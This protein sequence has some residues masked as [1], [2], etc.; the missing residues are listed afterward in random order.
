[1]PTNKASKTESL[2]AEPLSLRLSIDRTSAQAI[3][4]GRTLASTQVVATG[5][6]I[7][8]PNSSLTSLP[9]EAKRI[10]DTLHAICAASADTV[11]TWGGRPHK[12][13]SPHYANAAKGTQLIGRPGAERAAQIVIAPVDQPEQHIFTK[14]AVVPN[15]KWE[16][17]EPRYFLECEGNPTTLIAGN[18]IL[19]VTARN[20]ETK[21]VEPYPSSAP[22]VMTTLNR[23]LFRF[24]EDVAMQITGSK[25]G[26]FEPETRR[27]IASGNFAIVHDQWCCYLPADVSRFLQVLSAIF[28]PRAATKVGGFTSLAKQMGLSFEDILDER[29]GRVSAVKLEKRHGKNAAWSAVFYNKR[30]RV[31][32]M[33]QGKTL[34][35]DERTLIASNV[36]FDM[37]AHTVGIMRIIERAVDYLR[38]HRDQ[39]AALPDTTRLQEFIEGDPK[40][41]ARWL[42]FAVFILSHRLERGRMRRGSFEDYLVPFFLDDV[43]QLPSIVCCTPEGLQ[44]LEE[45]PDQVAKAWCEDKSREARGWA[46][47]LAK[48]ANCSD[49]VVYECRDD[50]LLTHGINI[51]IPYAYYRDLHLQPAITLMQDDERE[52]YHEARK[53]GDDHARLRVLDKAGENLFSQMREFVGVPISTP[54]TLLRAKVLGD[55]LVNSLQSRQVSSQKSLTARLGAD[56]PRGR[57]DSSVSPRRRTNFALSGVVKDAPAPTADEEPPGVAPPTEVIYFPKVIIQRPRNGLHN[58]VDKQSALTDLRAALR[59]VAVKLAGG[60]T[61][62]ERDHYDDQ[63]GEIERLIERRKDMTSRQKQT[64]RENKKAARLKRMGG[65]MRTLPAPPKRPQTPPKT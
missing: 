45:L 5:Q 18:N 44:V 38:V 41:T 13:I 6:A 10:V 19:P 64:R 43:L 37:T 26:L 20:P 57:T 50:W 23:V 16:S 1:M 17:G 40:P 29:G 56:D 54:P 27:A 35:D 52:A 3:P 33:R 34:A 61:T 2:I 58:G 59:E 42:E 22:R 4:S 21:V 9:R 8:A 55:A 48:A 65:P 12:F 31:G 28:H 51:E 47:R 25:V 62:K 15:G 32:G 63:Y 39:F 7:A 36:R 46:L 30:T 14:F 11:I 53:R 24:L 49:N 60:L